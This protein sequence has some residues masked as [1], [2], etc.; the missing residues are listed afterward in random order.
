MAT[1]AAARSGSANLVALEYDDLVAGVDLTAQIGKR[2]RKKA[3]WAFSLVNI[4]GLAEKQFLP[5]ANRFAGAAGH[6][7]TVR[8]ARAFY[9]AAGP[10]KLQAGRLREGNYYANPLYDRPVDDEESRVRLLRGAQRGRRR[11]RP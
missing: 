1:F 5:L 2:S 7:G 9:I 8:G 3:P 11:R 10:T 4:P 6:E